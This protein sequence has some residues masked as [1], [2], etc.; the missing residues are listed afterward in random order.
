M[1]ELAWPKRVAERDRLSRHLVRCAGLVTAVLSDG[2]LWRAGDPPGVAWVPDRRRVSGVMRQ[3]GD[4][5]GAGPEDPT[6]GTVDGEAA[7]SIRA[8]HRLAQGRAV[9]LMARSFDARLLGGLA[10]LVG[11]TGLI[12][13]HIIGRYALID[14]RLMLL[15][16]RVDGVA[17]PGRVDL[18]S[19]DRCGG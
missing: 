17:V 10:R 15:D 14:E 19:I 6:G 3:A 11:E 8:Y 16:L 1:F 2:Q 9:A 13:G 7:L 18:G 5:N 4:P 12:T